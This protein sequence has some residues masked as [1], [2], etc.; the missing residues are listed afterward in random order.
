MAQIQFTF[1]PNCTYDVKD[2]FSFL[3]KMYPEIP[4]DYHKL[5]DSSSSDSNKD[6][7]I[8]TLTDKIQGLEEDNKKYIETIS[9]LEEFNKNYTEKE[10]NLNNNII[11]LQGRI[12]ELE[13]KLSVYEPSLNGGEELKYFNIESMHLL[14]TCDNSA[15]FVG[16]VDSNSNAIFNFNIDKGEH[17]RFSQNP[18]ELKDFCEI[19]ESIDDANHI[20]LGEWGRGRYLQ[21]GML[22]VDTKAKIKLTRE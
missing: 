7:H 5:G 8:K 9:T 18:T 3:H 4:E 6:E 2:L 19:V 13:K 20:G 17:R 21:G 14:E 12:S 1:N 22:I 10:N 15:P 11:S 16:R